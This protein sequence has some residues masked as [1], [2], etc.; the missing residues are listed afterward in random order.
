MSR[1]RRLVVA[2][3]ALPL[4]LGA[5]GVV[6]D[7]D[8]AGASSGTAGQDGSA[9]DD[10]AG[11]GSSD[12][13]PQSEPA[14]T[15][16]TGDAVLDVR[17]GL[18]DA[19]PDVVESVQPSVVTILLPEGN[20]SGVVYAEDVVVTNEHVVRGNDEVVVALADGTRIRGEV[21]A[22]DR[23][24]D[25]AVIRTGRDDLPPATF[26]TAAP[27]A[28]SF[29]IAIG[30][31][32][33]FASTVTTGVISGLNRSI[34]G[35]VT[36][37][38]QALVDLIQTDAA[39]SPGNSGGA[40][41]DLDGEV[42]GI[43]EAYLPPASGAVSI[44][45]AIPADTVVDVVEQLLATGEVSL[46]FVGVQSDTLTPGVAEALG[47]PTD[48]GV[49][50]QAVVPDSP[51]ATGGLQDGDVVVAFAGE[52]VRT[53]GDFVGRIRNQDVGDAVEVV[54]LRGDEEVRLTLQLAERP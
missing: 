36:A 11:T 45:F 40:L 29:A 18:A 16:D 22:A 28:G 41:V 8:D 31:P 52:R 1:P 43:N 46:P 3:L 14:T 21:L 7:T 50:V 35:A 39:I 33:G 32:L 30:S 20:G 27:R 26:D 23:S 25:L 6:E 15:A 10:S 47:V 24:T 9:G 4:L 13:R 17:G 38:E 34:P 42:V 5:C 44:G 19:I 12:D 37:G 53:V 54:V 2:A 51:A 48:S 49:V